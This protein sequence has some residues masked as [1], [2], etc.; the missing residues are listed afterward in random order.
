MNKHQ[1]SENNEFSFFGG[2][3]KYKVNEDVG[4]QHS[5]RQNSKTNF[6]LLEILACNSGTVDPIQ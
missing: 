3:R 1:N 4:S 5:G 6:K 2:K